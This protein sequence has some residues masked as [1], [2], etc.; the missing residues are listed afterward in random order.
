MNRKYLDHGR[1]PL[2]PEQLAA[3]VIVGGVAVTLGAAH[4]LSTRALRAGTV[5]ARAG[6]RTLRNLFLLARHHSQ[7]RTTRL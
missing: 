2:P 3:V 6:T 7:A 5:T 1:E 4:L